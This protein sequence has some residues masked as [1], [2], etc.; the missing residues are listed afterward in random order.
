MANVSAVPYNLQPGRIED[1]VKG[2]KESH[3]ASTRALLAAVGAN[4]AVRGL[5]ALRKR[6]T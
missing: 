1:F 5:Q 6:R 4:L 3:D 2:A